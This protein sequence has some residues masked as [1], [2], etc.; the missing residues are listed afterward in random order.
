MYSVSEYDN[1]TVYCHFENQ[2][3][4]INNTDK[5]QENIIF[6]SIKNLV[7]TP[8][9]YTNNTQNKVTSHQENLI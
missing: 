6:S 8:N 5:S 3:S 7:L 2:K 9:V 1:K 4:K